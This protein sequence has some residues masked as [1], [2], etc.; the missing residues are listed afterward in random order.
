MNRPN[1]DGATACCCIRAKETI[2]PHCGGYASLSLA[3]ATT[4]RFNLRYA[5]LVDSSDDSCIP[6]I[7]CDV[8][9]SYPP[10]VGGQ[11]EAGWEN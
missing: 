6:R 1:R 11:D 3:G 5:V 10:C 9:P 2:R 8:V 4:P 7:V